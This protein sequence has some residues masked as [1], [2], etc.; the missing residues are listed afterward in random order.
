MLDQ[1]AQ[2]GIMK[3]SRFIKL[4]TLNHG[5]ADLALEHNHNPLKRTVTVD[6]PSHDYTDEWLAQFKTPL[7]LEKA[8]Q[9]PYVP[10]TH[11]RSLML[12][13]FVR[14]LQNQVCLSS[15]W[16]VWPETSSAY[17]APDP[18]T[19][20]LMPWEENCNDAL[21]SLRETAMKPKFWT[22]LSTHYS[23][24]NHSDTCIQDNISCVKSI[25]ELLDFYLMCPILNV[26]VS[27]SAVGRTFRGSATDPREV[28][29][30]QREEQTTR[31]CRVHRW[32]CWW[33]V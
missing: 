22:D 23:A 20:A 27:P 9:K 28:T 7:D 24:E 33:W 13:I 16:L 14:M 26:Y 6:D 10:F 29:G 17:L 31:C 12:R 15:G 4:R 5:P 1:Y 19:F 3:I 21:E 25:C 2:R 30:R 8:C 11:C 18:T 32:G